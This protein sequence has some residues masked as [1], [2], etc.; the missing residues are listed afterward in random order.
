MAFKY[1]A[2][3]KKRKSRNKFTGQIHIIRINFVTMTTNVIPTY[4]YI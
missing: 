3:E 2:P 1:L 4:V